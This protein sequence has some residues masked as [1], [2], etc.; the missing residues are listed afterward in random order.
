MNTHILA[1]KIALVNH[2][3]D[4]FYAFILKNVNFYVFLQKS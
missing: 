2:F 3:V 4:L 1:H